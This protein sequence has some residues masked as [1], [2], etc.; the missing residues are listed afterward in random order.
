MPST[1]RIGYKLFVS[2]SARSFPSRLT[3]RGMSNS[4]RGTAEAHTTAFSPPASDI[5]FE[6]SPVPPNPLGEGRWIET[7]GALVIG[8]VVRGGTG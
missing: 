4:S 3:L 7:A 2:V 8:C 1:F 6:L 5:R